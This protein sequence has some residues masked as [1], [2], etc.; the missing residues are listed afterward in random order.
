MAFVHGPTETKRWGD[1]KP[2]EALVE[3]EFREAS[4]SRTVRRV[5]NQGSRQAKETAEIIRGTFASVILAHLFPRSTIAIT[6]QVLQDD[7]ACLSV[8]IN[9]VTL[10]LTNAGI[11]MRDM[12]VS[13]SAGLV[14]DKEILDLNFAEKR[15]GTPVV[16][17][18]VLPRTGKIVTTHMTSRIKLNRM[19]DVMDLATKGCTQIHAVMKTEI[20]R[21]S[22]AIL[23]TRV[24]VD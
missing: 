7:G 16:Y 18:A 10:A 24:I 22:E 6:V 8:A 23:Q 3:V 9:A 2:D 11:P 5:Q 14:E 19:E 20:Q 4:F 15:V 17:V 13:C 1:S 12:V 21:H